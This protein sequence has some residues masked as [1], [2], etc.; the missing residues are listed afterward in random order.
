MRRPVREDSRAK[1]PHRLSLGPG[2]AATIRKY[3]AELVALAPDV[4]LASSSVALAPLLE[5]SRSTPMFSRVSPTRSKYRRRLCGL[6]YPEIR[7][8]SGWHAK[9]PKRFP[10]RGAPKYLI[11]DND[12]AFGAASRL[13][14]EQWVSG[15]GPPRSARPGRTD[16]LNA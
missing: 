1:S 16:M 14:C 11:R 15:T 5:A 9:S 10:G 4:I 3:A 12:R 8:P 6:R 7:R 2:N 13:A